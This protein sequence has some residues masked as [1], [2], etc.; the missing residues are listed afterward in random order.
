MVRQHLA[1]S[2][3]AEGRNLGGA[4]AG[5]PTAT[6]TSLRYDRWLE[7]SGRSSP[8]PNWQPAIAVRQ[9]RTHLHGRIAQLDDGKAG[10]ELLEKYLSL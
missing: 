6:S 2:I 4:T 3:S 8:K 7:L 5:E 1:N 9:V 10:Q